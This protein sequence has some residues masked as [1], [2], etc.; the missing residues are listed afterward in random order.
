MAGYIKQ[1]FKN[2]LKHETTSF[3]YRIDGSICHHKH[4]CTGP[5]GNP[6]EPFRDDRTG[7]AIRNTKYTCYRKNDANGNGVSI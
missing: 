7:K 4:F 2:Y 6:G 3:S 5:P 1:P